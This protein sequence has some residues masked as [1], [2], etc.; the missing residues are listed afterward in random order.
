MESYWL[1]PYGMD[2]K[3]Q[4]AILSKY[5][6]SSTLYNVAQ[7]EDCD[8]RLHKVWPILDILTI[9]SSLIIQF[10][11]TI[12]CVFMKPK[13][14]IFIEGRMACKGSLRLSVKII[15]ISGI[16]KFTVANLSQ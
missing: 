16:S 8:N 13:R 2:R 11:K 10:Y 1:T 3:C 15:M 12:R 6:N 14:I 9:D 5:P 4:F 7:P